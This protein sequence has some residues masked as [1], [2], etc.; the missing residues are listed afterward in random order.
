MRLFFLFFLF[1]LAAANGLAQPGSVYYVTSAP[2]GA[3]NPYDGL[4]VVISTGSLYVCKSGTWFAAAS[5]GGGTVTS[6]GISSNLGTASGSPVTTSGT[7]TLT[8]AASNI[9]SLFTGCSG[10]DYLGADD[11]CHA[12][13]GG[14]PGGANCAVQFN[15][16]S[17]F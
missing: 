13:S 12:A 3:C 1:V 17:S 4:Q 9:V 11:A 10:T 8:G 16:S 5:G 7:L 14:S 15:N 6:V 2:S